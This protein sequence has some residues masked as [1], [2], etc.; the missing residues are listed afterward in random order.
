MATN[1]SQTE[2]MRK[3][4]IM[5]KRL[6]TFPDVVFQ[7]T[8]RCLRVIQ[9]LVQ[10]EFF[11]IPVIAAKRILSLLLLAQNIAVSIRTHAQDWRHKP[12]HYDEVRPMRHYPVGHAGFDTEKVF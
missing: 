7:I 9:S 3:I 6:M 1:P 5:S 11:A 10:H 8:A 4:K 12:Q 2:A